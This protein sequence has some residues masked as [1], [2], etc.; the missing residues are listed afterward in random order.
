MRSCRS[1]AVVALFAA[2]P[3]FAGAPAA[4]P[5]PLPPLVCATA[6]TAAPAAAVGDRAARHAAQRGL[7][8]LAKASNQ[9]TQE[10]N[11]F[12][13]HVQ[14]VTL[15]ALTVG[16]HHQYDVTPKDLAAMVKALEMGVTAGGHTTG[17]AFEGQ[18]W[19]RYDE[20]ID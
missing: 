13:C 18:A 17:V 20:W 2:V 19:A 1:F 7:G 8:Y 3:A 9:W 5:A 14:A 4:A 12:G 6:L 11:C 16:K 15:E 10:H